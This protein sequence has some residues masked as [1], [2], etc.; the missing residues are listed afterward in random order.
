MMLGMIM[1]GR[2]WRG[3]GWGT[4]MEGG[5][6]VELFMQCHSNLG[7]TVKAGTISTPLP[8]QSIGSLVAGPFVS[9]EDWPH[10][11]LLPLNA[12]FKL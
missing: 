3:K 7:R 6:G 2:Y 12:S 11:L 10:C 4:E 8:Q 5:G 9:N 1:M